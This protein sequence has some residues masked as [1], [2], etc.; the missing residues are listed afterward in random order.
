MFHSPPSFRQLQY[1]V[2]LVQCEHFGKAAQQCHVTQ[3]TLSAGISEVEDILGFPLVERINKRNIR[4]TPLAQELAQ[5]A[6]ELLALGEKWMEYANILNDPL[7]VKVKIGII[8]TIAPFLLPA[9]L[10]LSRKRYPKLD[11]EIMES[12][13]QSIVGAVESGNMDF[14]I[15]ALPYELGRLEVKKLF[16][17]NFMAAIPN[18]HPLGKLKKITADKLSGEQLLLLSE[19]HCLT[20]HALQI[21]KLSFDKRVAGSSLFTLMQLVK[22]GSGIT[23]VPEMS[24]PSLSR[25]NSQ[26]SFVPLAEPGPHREIALLYRNSWSNQAV[27]DVLFELL[28]SSHK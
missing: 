25:L 27:V 28:T 3:S 26:I 2:A 21:C 20:D 22:G 8:P 9:F 11:V 1:L 16:P 10:P 23:I 15:L 14:G 6:Q 13:S 19:G 24:V 12:T 18:Q 17:D 7:S 5:K 4:I